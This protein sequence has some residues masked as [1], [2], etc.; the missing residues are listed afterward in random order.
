MVHAEQKAALPVIFH[1]CQEAYLTPQLQL[2]KETALKAPSIRQAES[3][4]IEGLSARYSQPAYV[5][6]S[7]GRGRSTVPVSVK[8]PEEVPKAV[9]GLLRGLPAPDPTAHHIIPIE[10]ANTAASSLQVHMKLDVIM[11]HA[12][13]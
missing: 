1:V 2:Q 5:A 7:A 9:E 12:E 6:D 8:I 3:W 13:G 11:T 4:M 10:A